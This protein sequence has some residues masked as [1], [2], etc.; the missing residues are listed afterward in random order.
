MNLLS[1]LGLVIDAFRGKAAAGPGAVV[2]TGAVS[3][4][5]KTAQWSGDQ[6]EQVKHL[7]HWVYVAIRAIRDRVAAAKLNLTAQ[8][9]AEWVA[10]ND[11]PFLDVLDFV[12]PVHTRWDLWAGTVEFLELTGNAYWY[13]ASDRL[14]VPREIWPLHSQ[15]VKVIPDKA[16]IVGGY[17]YSTGKSGKKPVT[18]EPDEVVHFKYPN[19][20]NYFYGWSPLQAAAEAVDAHEEMLS[21][22]TQAFRHGV[23][24][25]K[26]VFTTPNVI[27]DEKVLERLANRLNEKYAGTDNAQKIMVAHGGLEPKP[28]CLTPQEMDFLDSKRSSRDEILAIFGTP[29]S[30]VGISED[31]NRAVADAMERTFTRNTVMPKLALIAGAIQQNLLQHYPAKLRCAFEPQVPEDREQIRADATA[32]FDRGALT[33]DELRETLTAKAPTGDDTRYTPANL[34]PVDADRDDGAAEP[35]EDE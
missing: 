5:Q 29:A 12:N 25:P 19:P 22:Q 21:A 28:L 26:M 18:F 32:A 30:V 16:R 20:T 14:G 13:I 17:E 10:I 33:V 15:R 6:A 34:L 4:G 3:P 23:Q 9:G 27:S 35:D 31:S 24:P 7:K 8:K 11:H 1:R 2:V